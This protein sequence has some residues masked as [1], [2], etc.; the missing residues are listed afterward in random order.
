MSAPL[1]YKKVPRHRSWIVAAPGEPVETPGPSRICVSL[2]A[3]DD[4]RERVRLALMQG[5][6]NALETFN[7]ICRNIVGESPV[8]S[9]AQVALLGHLTSDSK[10]SSTSMRHSLQP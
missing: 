4:K 2:S 7:T 1:N 5:S 10:P 9:A 8:G 6:M 3:A